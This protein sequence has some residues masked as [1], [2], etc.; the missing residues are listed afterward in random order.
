MAG[1][2]ASDVLRW[3]ASREAEM[4]ALLAVLV[5]I[6]SGT[7]QAEGVA[8]VGR[9]LRHVLDRHGIAS[10]PIDGG[11]FG[12]G[13]RA[14]PPVDEA[15]VLLMGH[16]DT[17]FPDGEARRRPF[18]VRGD[19][20]YGPGVADM[21]GGLVMNV[22]V[23]AALRACGGA[24]RPVALLCTADEE[25]GSP[26]FRPII[27]AEAR[28]CAF[29]F[30]AEPGRASGNLVTR[31][32]GGTFMRLRVRGKAAHSGANFRDGISAIGELAHKIVALHALTDLDA[33][34]TC[35]V[36]V[37]SGGQTV[38]T[39]AP[40]AEALIDLRFDTGSTGAEAL[41]RIRAIAEQSFI[42]GASAEL[43]VTGSFLP[44]EPTPATQDL[45][46][47]YQ[48]SAR[49]V[50]FPV[51]GEATGGCADSGFAAAAGAVTLCGTGPVGGKAHTPDEYIELSSLLQ[52]AQ[53]LALTILRL[54]Q[55]LSPSHER[56]GP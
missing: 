32:R 40:D 52:R 55:P 31:R 36:G 43:A 22:F 16:M 48:A 20:A 33:G 34:V 5:D 23:A 19:R 41:Q 35:N 42:Q 2:Q 9:H 44:L 4:H 25:I 26:H 28:H 11:A 10:A 47:L 29:A 50:G 51:E 37:V 54:P 45:L 7:G 8:A 21:K 53:A 46:A 13:F 17:V 3:L 27:A 1:A 38:N 18:S 49:D 15:R 12:P 56:T 24:A 39:V 6:D 14:G 30:N